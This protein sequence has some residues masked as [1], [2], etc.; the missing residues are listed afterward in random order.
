MQ[1]ICI[2]SAP[3][4]NKQL[5]QLSIKGDMSTQQQNDSTNTKD[6]QLTYVEW[7]SDRKSKGGA[8]TQ[9][10]GAVGVPGES[11]S[12]AVLLDLYSYTT[13]PLPTTV[14]LGVGGTHSSE[15]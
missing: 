3:S 9:R 4:L 7:D 13:Y 1:W 10:C 8:Y 12:S 5:N 15:R 14:V 2:N 6:L 11:R